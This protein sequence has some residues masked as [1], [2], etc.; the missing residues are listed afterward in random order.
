MDSKWKKNQLGLARSFFVPEVCLLS[1]RTQ[2]TLV[3]SLVKI[4]P[5][6]TLRVRRLTD[7]QLSKLVFTMLLS[8]IG[9]IWPH[10]DVAKHDRNCTTVNDCQWYLPNGL[11][12]LIA[13]RCFKTYVACDGTSWQEV[14]VLEFPSMFVNRIIAWDFRGLAMCGFCVSGTRLTCYIID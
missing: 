12:S 13:T 4:M 8:V 6:W 11:R 14:Y 7:V 1:R 10:H 3:Y 5:T 2:T 9:A